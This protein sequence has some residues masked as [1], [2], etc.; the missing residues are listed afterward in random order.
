M[1]ITIMVISMISIEFT[2]KWNRL[3]D[4]YSINSTGQIIPLMVGI[5]SMIAVIWKLWRDILVILIVHWVYYLF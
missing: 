3:E 1:G 2:L 4:I 5:G